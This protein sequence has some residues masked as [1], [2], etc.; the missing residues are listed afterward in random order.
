MKIKLTIIIIGLLTTIFIG[1]CLDDEL[2]E[3]VL[4]NFEFL[5][6]ID[7]ENGKYL[8]FDQG[9]LMLNALEFD[10]VREAGED[11]YFLSTFEEELKVDFFEK[12]INQQ[13]S[14]DIPQGIYERIKL[15]IG[16]DEMT[17]GP[18]LIFGGIYS[19][20]KDGDIPVRI[21][22][23]NIDPIEMVAENISSDPDI[24]LNKEIP[25]TVEI[26][27]DPDFLLQ[28]ANSRQL[29]S[30]DISVIDGEPMIIISNDSNSV[31][32]NIIVNRLERSA[33]AVFN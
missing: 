18:N 32:F 16:N 31:I 26:S 20:L 3:P 12:T 23:S 4:V 9:E 6:D 27:F 28:M 13:V 25:T 11:F 2:K 19:S 22:F 29:E 8:K 10:G 30:A 17:T 15:R 24:V 5:M 21:E 1:S 33:K 14:F 7:I